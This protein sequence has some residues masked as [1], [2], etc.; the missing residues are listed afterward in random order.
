M[1]AG[2]EVLDGLMVGLQELQLWDLLLFPGESD[3]RKLWKRS[4]FTFCVFIFEA[5]S[6]LHHFKMQKDDH[7]KRP[8][9]LNC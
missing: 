8:F 2:S 4:T 7:H 1:C 3:R 6:N 9:L 5:L